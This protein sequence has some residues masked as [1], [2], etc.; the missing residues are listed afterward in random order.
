MLEQ[1]LSQ[2]NSKECSITHSDQSVL[3]GTVEWVKMLGGKAVQSMSYQKNCYENAVIERFF[4]VLKSECTHTT[5]TLITE[6]QA[7]I[8][9]YWHITTQNGLSLV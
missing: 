2:F 3:Y 9:E 6:L 1:G 8:E 4:T 5:S 7:K